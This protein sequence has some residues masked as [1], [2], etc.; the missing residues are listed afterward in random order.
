SKEFNP[1]MIKGIFDNLSGAQPKNHFTIGIEDDLSHTSLPYDAGFSIEDPQGVQ[2]IFYGL[3]SDG[4]V[5]ANKNSIKIIGTETENY[6]QGY[7]VYD[8]KKA[9]SVTVSHL[10]FGPNPI[11]ATYLVSKASFVGCHQFSFLEKYD[12]LDTIKENGVFL[13]NSPYGPDEVWDHIPYEIQE[14][15]IER[16]AKFYV[17]DAYK[18]A[19]ET[20]MGV[21]INT[22]MQTCFFAISGVLPKD[23][24]I[25]AIKNAIKKTYGSK[26]EE[27]VK[28][29][30]VAVDQSLA[31]LHEVKVQAKATSTIRK[32]PVVPDQAPE[33]VKSVTAKMMAGKGDHIPVASLPDDGTYP[34]GTTKWEKRNIALQIPVWDESVCI[35]CGKCIA[36]CPHATVRMKAYD[37]KVLDGAPETFKSTDAKTKEWEGQKFT[38]QVAPEDCTGCTLCIEACPAKNKV[39]PSK[40]ALNMAEQAPLR[41]QEQKNWEFFEKIPEMDRSKVRKDTIRTVQAL[42]PLFEFSG[43]CAGCGETPYVKLITQLFGDRMIVANATGCSSIYGGNLPTTP[44]TVN[45]QGRGP[46]WSNSLFEDNAEFGLGFRLTIDKQ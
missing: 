8:S 14:K 5:G 18:V 42:Q 6:A 13:L 41:E 17:I 35:Q 4:T 9:G 16:K 23:E 28:K 24:A 3:G 46:A 22:I 38:I 36:V 43:C 25:A 1:G 10:R 37:P 19:K 21:R 45:A 39:D 40:K 2:A 11:R 29:N 26:G 12:V 15:L 44:Y 34:T 31:H 27:I 30:Y 7:F 33:F 20:G 32:K